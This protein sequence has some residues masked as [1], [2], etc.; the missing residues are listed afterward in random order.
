MW[1][2]QLIWSNVW[3]G[4][5]E[6]SITTPAFF[7]FVTSGVRACERVSLFDSSHLN[8]SSATTGER[9]KTPWR[10][11]HCWSANWSSQLIQ[12]SPKTTRSCPYVSSC[13]SR[14]CKSSLNWDYS[15]LI[16]L[17][18]NRYKETS[19]YSGDTSWYKLIS[20]M[21]NYA[22]VSTKQRSFW[23]YALKILSIN[24]L[25]NNKNWGDINIH[26]LYSNGNYS[27]IPPSE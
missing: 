20:S 8:N 2:T 27:A 12:N 16:D 9:E 21:L 17:T 24:K 3:A 25:R 18:R 26:Q 22:D 13:L 23:L 1:S 7:S 10:L 4:L 15:K 14:V 5:K 19:N 11:S 6:L